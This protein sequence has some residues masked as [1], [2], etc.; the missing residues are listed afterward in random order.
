MVERWDNKKHVEVPCPA[1]VTEYNANMG[2]VDLF[3]MLAGLYRVDHKSRKWYRR[4]FYW[5]LNVAC[6]NSWILYRRHCSQL[7]VPNKDVLDLLG[8]VTRISQCLIVINKPAPPLQ[9]G[10]PSIKATDD[11]EEQAPQQKR[12]V[13]SPLTEIQLDN[14]GHLPEHKSVKGRCR[15]CKT[16][17]IRTSCIKCGVFLC[18]TTDKN[19]YFSNKPADFHVSS[20]NSKSSQTGSNENGTENG[21]SP[22]CINIVY[23]FPWGMETIEKVH[24]LGDQPFQDLS[25]V[26]Q[27]KYKGLV[28]GKEAS[29]PHCIVC[30]TSLETATAALLV[31]SY[32]ERR[33]TSTDS[34]TR[35]SMVLKLHSQISPFQIAIA[36]S[37]TS[38]R[39]SELR[40]V[41]HHLEKDF[42][43]NGVS[44]FNIS[45]QGS[46]LEAHFK[47]N[48]QL[49]IHYT[50][51]VSDSTIS[52]GLI[53]IRH[54]D[55]QI[56]KS[57]HIGTVVE[58][59]KRN[60]SARLEH[61]S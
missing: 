20:E 40:H 9:R 21:M 31:D 50:I 51:I 23:H 1:A 52:E 29:L 55:T 8:F 15:Q 22:K 53:S 18:L 25:N 46:T 30:D 35:P 3:D 34:T 54:R 28:T 13:N 59:I 39:P 58:D 17:I 5:A 27:E 14:V 33:M 45:E 11:K 19:C 56:Q 6:V 61:H 43:R 32:Y 10:R 38:T 16:S 4:I 60:L 36:V 37:N 57:S 24:S 48:D 44:L 7:S 47:R 26:E 49:G 2:G 12:T 42:K 41:C